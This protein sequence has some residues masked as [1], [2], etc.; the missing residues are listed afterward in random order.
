MMETYYSKGEGFLRGLSDP[1]APELMGE[2]AR[3]A[4]EFR[5]SV[6]MP[7]S[8][9]IHCPLNRKRYTRHGTTSRCIATCK[10]VLVYTVWICLCLCRCMCQ[11]LISLSVFALLRP[12]S[13]LSLSPA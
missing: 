6:C 1:E 11:W 10:I 12:S 3:R 4:G 8:S 2:G 7:F 5:L 13:L 9:V